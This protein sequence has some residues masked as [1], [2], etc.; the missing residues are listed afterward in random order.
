VKLEKV[1]KKQRRKIMKKVLVV[2]AILF[3]SSMTALAQ[4]NSGNTGT[5]TGSPGGGAYGSGMMGD[6]GYGSGSGSTGGQGYGPGPGMMGGQGYGMGS[7]NMMQGYNQSPECQEFY[8]ETAELRKE[9]HVKRFEYAETQRD[10]KTTGETTT[11]LEKEVQE[12]QEK[13]SAKAP[14]GCSW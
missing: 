9:L 11:K 6:Q 3:L 13:I 4:E 7:G 1:T 5:G 8:N 10:P 2:L 14:S 12:L